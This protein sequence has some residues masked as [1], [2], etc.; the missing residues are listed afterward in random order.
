MLSESAE[1]LKYG[2]KGLLDNAS[3]SQTVQTR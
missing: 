2:Q 3:V 1:G